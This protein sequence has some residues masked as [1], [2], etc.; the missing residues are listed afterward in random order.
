MSR[1]FLLLLLSS[2]SLLQAQVNYNA[3][4]QVTPYNGKFRMGINMGYY[5][6]WDNKTLANIAA[7]NSTLGLKG[8][9]ARSNRTGLAEIVLDY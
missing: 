3:N 1:F 9:G 2:A 7:G 6:G 5:P 8:I 4:T